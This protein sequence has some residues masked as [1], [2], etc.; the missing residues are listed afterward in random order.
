MT[1]PLSGAAGQFIIGGTTMCVRNPHG[2]GARSRAS[3]LAIPQLA[4]GTVRFPVP[5]PTQEAIPVHAGTS[6]H[7]EHLS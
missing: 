4:A 5:P 3:W 2:A 1:G 6:P 7:T